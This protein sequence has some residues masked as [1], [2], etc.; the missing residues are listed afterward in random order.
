MKLLVLL[1]L[2]LLLLPLLPCSCCLLLCCRCPC[3]L[4]TCCCYSQ[5]YAYASAFSCRCSV[6][7]VATGRWPDISAAVARGCH[8]YTAADGVQACMHACLP[9][10][11]CKNHAHLGMVLSRLMLLPSQH[12]PDCCCEWKS[13]WQSIV[14]TSVAARSQPCEGRLKASCNRQKEEN[15]RKGSYPSPKPRLATVTES[16]QDGHSWTATQSML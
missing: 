15:R 9:A 2:P 6:L 3:C 12:T 11:A 7:P 1:L 16:Q 13:G 14:H 10:A 4:L 5:V 8:V